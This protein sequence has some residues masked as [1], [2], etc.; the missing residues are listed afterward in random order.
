MKSLVIGLGIGNLYTTVLKQ[1][2]ATV[3]TV[4]Q[5][6]NKSP[7]FTTISD[8]LAQ[9]SSLIPYIFAHLTTHTPKLPS[10]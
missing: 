9:V 3:F 8:A 10:K 6:K 1:I 5:D 2:G 4:D 7:D